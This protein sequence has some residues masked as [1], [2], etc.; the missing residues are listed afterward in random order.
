MEL[1]PPAPSPGHSGCPANVRLLD[2]F[3]L[4]RL[5]SSQSPVWQNKAS[6]SR[7]PVTSV[8]VHH[9]DCAVAAYALVHEMGV[10]QRPPQA[11]VVLQPRAF[12]SLGSFRSKPFPRYCGRDGGSLVPGWEGEKE[13]CRRRSLLFFL[14]RWLGMQPA[15]RRGGCS[16]LTQPSARS[17][18]D[19]AGTSILLL[20]VG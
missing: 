5:Q 15:W 8:S 3:P 10:R 16:T 11:L 4:P 19:D 1:L 18:P 20:I 9:E 13:E 17:R 6:L 7:R 12:K 2:K 14:C